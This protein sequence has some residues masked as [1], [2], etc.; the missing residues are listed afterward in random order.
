MSIYNFSALEILRLNALR[1]AKSDAL[2]QAHIDAHDLVC[3][4]Q[5]D[6]CSVTEAVALEILE[7][8]HKF[9]IIHH[10]TESG[11]FYGASLLGPDRN[12]CDYVWLSLYTKPNAHGRY[13]TCSASDFSKYFL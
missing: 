4:N 6:N 1:D 13:E 12:G 8:L 7:E 11:E 10:N 9:A 2:L 3:S 5:D